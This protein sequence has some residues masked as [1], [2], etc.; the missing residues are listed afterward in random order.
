MMSEVRFESPL[1]RQGPRLASADR[2]TDDDEWRERV[3]ALG[4]GRARRPSSTAEDP[5]NAAAQ[6]LARAW[7][8]RCLRARQVHLEE[9][10][11]EDPISFGCA[12]EVQADELGTR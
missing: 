12:D 2:A 4:K 9:A 10:V 1:P 8:S 6:N 3:R 7:C 5:S 11:A